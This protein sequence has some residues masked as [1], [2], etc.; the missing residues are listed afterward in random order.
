MLDLVTTPKKGLNGL[1]NE[2]ELQKSY[3][4]PSLNIMT[5]RS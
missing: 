3:Q 2:M 1:R 4:L 5:Q